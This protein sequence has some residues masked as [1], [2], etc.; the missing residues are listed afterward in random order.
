MSR[1]GKQT[2]VIPDKTDVS[3]TDGTLS[4]KGPK[5]E[6]SRPVHSEVG[7]SVA[8]GVVSVSPRKS[9][10]LARSLWGTYAAHVGNMVRGVNEPFEKRL[11]LEGIGYKVELLGKE[12]KFSVGFSHPVIVDIPDDIAV[13]VEKNVISISGI[14]RESVGQFAARVRAVKKP[15]PYKGKGIRYENEVVRRKQ[16]KKATA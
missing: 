16:G 3:V 4:V 8:E 5:G 6:L 12:L 9:T 1:I 11:V 13:S 2:I 14:S 7:I 10:K 15:E